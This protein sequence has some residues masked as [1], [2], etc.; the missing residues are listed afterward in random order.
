[1]V[2]EDARAA[3]GKLLLIMGCGSFDVWIFCHRSFAIAGNRAGGGW[4]KL[5]FETTVRANPPSRLSSAIGTWS[6]ENVIGNSDSIF[7]R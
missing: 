2:V 7:R 1:M 3:Q 6:I 5:A 4:V